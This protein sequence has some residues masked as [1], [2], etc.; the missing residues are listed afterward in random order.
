MSIYFLRHIKT[1][2]NLENLISGCFDAE[3]LSGQALV[4][5]DGAELRF[6]HVLCSPLKRCKATID[7]LPA[8]CY[9]DVLYCE[10]L[11]ERNVGILEGMPRSQAQRDYPQ[12]F[13]NG[14]LNVAASIPEG[15][16]IAEALQRIAPVVEKLRNLPDSMNVLVCS[17]N[18]TLKILLAAFKNI[19]ISNEYWSSINFEHGELWCADSY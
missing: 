3:P 16:S 4:V 13:S 18:Q 2:Y 11:V 19:P 14:K 17:H 9:D 15:E 5:P 12:L 10:E 7:L 8:D 1:I 6:H